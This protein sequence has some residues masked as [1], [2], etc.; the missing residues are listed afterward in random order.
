MQ[1]QALQ[2]RGIRRDVLILAWM[3]LFLA[4][5][6][7]FAQEPMAAEPM[8]IVVAMPGPRVAPFLPLE[9]MARLGFDRQE[10]FTLEIRHFG[11]GPL[12]AKDLIDRN[13]D[14]A[15]LGMPAL[16][17]I[18]LA[19][20]G[21]RS[22]APLTRVPA[23]TLMARRG[24]EKDLRR[25]SQLRGRTIGVHSGSKSGKSTAQQMT[26]FLLSRAGIG[27]DEV[28]YVPAGQK[29]EEYS[30]ALLSGQVDAI[31][32]NEP[33][34]SLLVER[35]VAYRL[36]DLH[37]PAKT[38]ELFGGLFLYTQL[39]TRDDIIRNEPDKVNRLVAALRRTQQWMQAQDAD[40][41]VAELGLADSREKFALWRFL[42]DHKAI[43]SPDTRFS[44]E[45][46]V[47]S[48]NFFRAVNRNNPAA[49]ELR[50]RDLIVDRWA[51]RDR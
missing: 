38:R 9:L 40:R 27:P 15:G 35:G 4:R 31:M 42:R 43:Y 33:A 14:F 51:G 23:Y 47:N 1:H 28:N 16:A 49:A 48:E 50:F 32:T 39:A 19:S 30:A 2:G 29:L 37:D 11:G 12:A 45:Q 3:A 44:D 5:F 7:L 26:E 34:A 13:S 8:R 22:I 46:L 24:L 18:H 17:G 6:G 10:K 36:A 20:P 41:I 25:I 21:I